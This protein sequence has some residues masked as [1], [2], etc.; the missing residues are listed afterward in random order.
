M[1]AAFKALIIKK[2]ISVSGARARHIIS[3]FY[4]LH[5]SADMDEDN[6]GE[7]NR[8]IMHGKC[9]CSRDHI[10]G[11]ALASDTDVSI[12]TEHCIH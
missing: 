7:N 1:N 6:Q 5:L 10:M 2:N 8:F 9:I 4:I 12:E 11:S 3:S